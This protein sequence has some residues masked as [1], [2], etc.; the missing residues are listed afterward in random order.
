VESQ[1]PRPTIGNVGRRIQRALFPQELGAQPPVQKDRRTVAIKG[2]AKKTWHRVRCSYG[3]YCS[4]LLAIGF[5]AKKA[6]RWNSVFDLT[7]RSAKFARN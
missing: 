3:S 2:S 4:K 5:P 1:I 6:I 7:E